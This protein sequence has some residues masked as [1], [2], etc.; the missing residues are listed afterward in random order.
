MKRAALAAVVFTALLGV[1]PSASASPP[2]V[3]LLTPTNGTTLAV[4][5]YGDGTTTFTWHVS[6]DTPEATTVMFELGTDSSFAPGTFTG[7]NFACTAANPNC[8]TSFAPPRSYS[9]P[10]P[11]TYYWRVGLTTSAGIVWSSTS[12]FKVVNKVDK[13]KPRVRVLPGSAKRGK[14][15]QLL[16]R[17]ADDRGRV[18]LRVTLEYHGRTLYSGRMPMTVTYWAQPMF[19]YSRRPLPRFLPAGRY[20]ACARAWDESGNTARS[21]AWYRVR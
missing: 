1:T 11:Q 14:R 12:M 6:W 18:R 17:A 7:E 9:P 13:V 19:F 8:A 5:A 4:P 3:T 2:Q 21:C 15:A 20:Q 10:F 16:V